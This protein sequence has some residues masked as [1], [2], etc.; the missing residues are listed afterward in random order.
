VGVSDESPSD[1]DGAYD[2][3]FEMDRD[4]LPT[5]EP[6]EPV[7]DEAEPKR[8]IRPIRFTIKALLLIIVAVFLLPNVL[9]GFRQAAGTVRLVNP[10]LLALGFGLQLAALF[11]Y[12]LLTRASLGTAGHILSHARIFRIQLSTKA[13]SNIVPGGNAAGSA[14]GYRLLTLSGIKGPDAGFALATSGI[15]SA[16][17][18]NIIF[19]TALI[20]SIPSR[21]VNPLYGYAAVAGVIIMG[22]TAALVVGVMDGSGRAE[23]LVRRISRKLGLDEDKFAAVLHQVGYRLEELTSDRK[24]LVRVVFWATA[25]WLLDVA[26][27]WVFLRAFGGSISADALIVAFGL[28]NVLAAIPI[29]P[30]G[31]GVVEATYITVLVGF[32]LPRKVVVPGIA[33]YR[34]AQYLMPIALGALA[35]ASLRVGPWKIEK[36]DRLVGLRD[37][38]RTE[39]ERG[40]SRM[41][42]VLRLGV[43][44]RPRSEPIDERDTESDTEDES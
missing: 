38:A 15:G 23:R 25:N 26:S 37:L 5:S 29:L 34:S 21:G 9:S 31:L 35:Y 17:V 32:G 42:F 6:P 36:R 14:L 12:S 28:A 4:V 20:V 33:A 16:V 2:E 1:F 43:R 24:L 40:E 19:W 18:L 30:G 27:L 7:P 13:L 22:I 41:D 8:K 44:R 39:S 3:T 11:C 10:A